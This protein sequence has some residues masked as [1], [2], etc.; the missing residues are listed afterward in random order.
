MVEPLDQCVCPK[1]GSRGLYVTTK[2]GWKPREIK[3]R[4]IQKCGWCVDLEQ[5]WPNKKCE[6]CPVKPMQRIMVP[7]A[8]VGCAREEIEKEAKR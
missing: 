6:S 1:C 2:D 5:F 7:A 8:C 4:H 3:C